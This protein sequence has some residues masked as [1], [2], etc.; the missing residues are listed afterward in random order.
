[1]KWR[2]VVLA[3]ERLG[4]EQKNATIL[5]RRRH[6]FLVLVLKDSWSGRKLCRGVREPVL[7]LQGLRVQCNDSVGFP[8]S[9]DWTGANGREEC[10]IGR[11]CHGAH[12]RPTVGLP[13]HDRLRFAVEIYRPDR[14]RRS[15]AA[16]RRGG[17]QH[18][19]HRNR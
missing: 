5:R 9:R 10:A 18:R 15:A 13:R 7:E 8:V 17:V 16:R 4:I 3:A 2:G 1:M 12:H 19:V 6:N 14:V 11:E